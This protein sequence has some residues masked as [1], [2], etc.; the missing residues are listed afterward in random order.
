MLSFLGRRVVYSAIS[1]VG[2]M[3][4]VFFLARL[5]GDPSFLYL[6]VDSTQAMRS[7]FAARHGFDQPSYIQFGLFL[8]EVLSLDFGSSLYYKRPALEVVLNAFPTTLLL[9]FFTMLFS[10]TISIVT[11]SLAAAKPGGVFD[12]IATALA[13]TGASA[14]NFWIAIVGILV[15]AV[16]LR[17][18]PTSGIGGPQY[19]ILPI[20]VLVV[21]P[22]G[23][24]VQVVRGSMISAL[25]SSYVRTARAK[26]A[27]A[28]SVIF[29]HALRNS[30]LPVITVAGDLAA[31]ILNG[32]VIVETVFGF[33][34][35]GKLMIDAIT[36]RDF[37]VLQTAVMVSAIAIFI[38]NIAIDVIYVT[39]DPRVRTE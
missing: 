10:L 5:T 25:S 28:A 8:R 18:V 7:E 21:G 19:W 38:M 16:W 12:R 11:G 6:P 2:L 33:P 20:A 37:A 3:V 27:G 22:C 34:G 26:G 24:L 17:L 31:G 1:L 14:P 30:M 39:L 36:N 9:A 15:F 35:I 29:V 32:A 4:L 13:L 23:R